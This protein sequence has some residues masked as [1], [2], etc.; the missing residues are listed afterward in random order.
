M[1]H[2]TPGGSMSSEETIIDEHGDDVTPIDIET[3]GQGEIELEVMEFLPSKGS[4]DGTKYDEYSN[5]IPSESL[6]VEVT[7]SNPSFFERVDLR[8]VLRMAKSEWVTT[9]ALIESAEVKETG[10][11]DPFV[12]YVLRD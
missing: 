4:E 1:R 5:S 11:G 10:K 6:E 8:D 7:T 9:T 2:N 12:A 3:T